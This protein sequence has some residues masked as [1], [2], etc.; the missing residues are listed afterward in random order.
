MAEEKPNDLQK[1]RD[2][3]FN[4][5][6][7]RSRSIREMRDKL[8]DKEFGDELIDQ[9]VA[10]LERLHL[11]DDR[12]FARGWIES[13]MRNRPSGT[14]RLAR[15]LHQKGIDKEIVDELLEE[16]GDELDSAETAAGLLR[17]QGWRYTGLEEMKAKRRML[18][19]LARRGYDA[20]TARKAI[21]TV[22]EELQQNDVEG[23]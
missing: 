19:F 11:L 23:D 13:R 21:E 15:E 12:A 22:W 6:S 3:A 18:G 17:R 2:A 4:Y 9:V 10:D 20:D 7:V 16:F 14:F 5:L 1:A 8:R